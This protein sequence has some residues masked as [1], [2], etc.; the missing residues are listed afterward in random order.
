MSPSGPGG[1]EQGWL[2]PGVEPAQKMRLLP[3]EN[4]LKL[5]RTPQLEGLGEPGLLLHAEEDDVCG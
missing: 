4:S 5:R 2:G 1:Q 3:L